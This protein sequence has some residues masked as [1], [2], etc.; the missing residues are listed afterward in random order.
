[1]MEQA[2]PLFL[3]VGLPTIPIMLVL[4]KMV[5]WDHYLLKLWW[6]HAGRFVYYPGIL[7]F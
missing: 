4:G 2:D 5:R 7:L 6:R 1:M 3:L